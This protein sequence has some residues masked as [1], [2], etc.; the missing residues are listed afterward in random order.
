MH[1]KETR[2]LHEKNGIQQKIITAS[3]FNKFCIF[4]HASRL[5][6]YPTIAVPDPRVS[7]INTVQIYNNYIGFCK[8]I[9]RYMDRETAFRCRKRTH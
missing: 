6:C 9:A 3:F 7:E 8:V 5:R 4:I 1:S 2:Q